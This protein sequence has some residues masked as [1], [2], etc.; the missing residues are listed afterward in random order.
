M[1]SNPALP[2]GSLTSKPT[3]SSASWCSATSVFCFG[4]NVR[5]NRRIEVRNRSS[6][7]IVLDAVCKYATEVVSMSFVVKVSCQS[8]HCGWLTESD[9]DETQCI[10][11]REHATSFQTPGESARA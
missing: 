8:K 1:K 4:G 9:L 11:S 5:G 2:G 10:G 7:Q 3:W 6:E